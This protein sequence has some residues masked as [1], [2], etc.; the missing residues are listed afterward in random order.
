MNAQIVGEDE[1]GVGLL[2]E[3]NRGDEH[4]IGLDSEGNIFHHKEDV[5]PDT[6]S[7]RSNIE[8]ETFSQARRYARYH[9]Y[10][11]KGY[12]TVPPS[13]NPDRLAAVLI[14]LLDLTDKQFW[15]YFQTL[16]EQSVSHDRTD[17]LPPLDLPDEVYEEEFLIYKQN[18][19]L[20]DDLD[21]IQSQLDRPA[22]EVIGE[23]EREEL[24]TATGQGMLSKAT[25]LV[26]GTSETSDVT[27]TE[28]TIEGVSGIDTMYYEDTNEERT[29]ES[30]DQFDRKPDARIEILPST[31]ECDDFRYVV[32]HNLVCQIRDCYIGM[33]L[34]P[35]E[36]YKVLGHGRYKYTGKYRHFDFYEPYFDHEARISGY[37]SPV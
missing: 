33:G 3:D 30:Q 32:G 8:D 4:E 15:E 12:D 14:A 27:W 26:G 17:A 20:E 37:V 13:E 25:S 19:Y 7:D 18:V 35:P 31:Y 22:T 2:V 5:I 34:E 9:V 28:L 10:R 29:I 24:A 1:K 16:H 11:E 6:P 21:T 36:P 23:I